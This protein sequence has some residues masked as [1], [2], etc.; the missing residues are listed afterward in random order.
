M[1]VNLDSRNNKENKYVFLICADF[2]EDYV[3]TDWTGFKDDNIINN[4]KNIVSNE[5]NKIMSNIISA[6]KK[7]RKISILTK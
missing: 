4:V 5:I 2:L 7:E 6:N 3:K 1:G